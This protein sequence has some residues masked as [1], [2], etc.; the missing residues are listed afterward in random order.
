MV[1]CSFSIKFV[2]KVILQK[3]KQILHTLDSHFTEI[4]WNG[5]AEESVNSDAVDLKFFLLRKIRHRTMSVSSASLQQLFFHSTLLSYFF[6]VVILLLS[7]VAFV[8][9]LKRHRGAADSSPLSMTSILI[10]LPSRF[11]SKHSF[12]LISFLKYDYPC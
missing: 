9:A 6:S 11:R 12:N 7:P 5:V 4:N 8:S 2:K 3:D 1:F 10:W